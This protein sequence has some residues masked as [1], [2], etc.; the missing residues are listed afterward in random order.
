LPD[1]IANGRTTAFPFIG[2]LKRSIGS[3]MVSRLL[4]GNAGESEVSRAT[5]AERDHALRGDFASAG[6]IVGPSR[7]A[8]RSSR[9]PVFQRIRTIG[10]ELEDGAWYTWKKTDSQPR[11]HRYF[12]TPADSS[13][14]R[15]MAKH[16]V[17]HDG[18]GIRMEAD[19]FDE[20]GMRL[21]DVEFV[22]NP[23]PLST[24]GHAELIRALHQ[25]AQIYSTIIPLRGRDHAEGG[26]V[27]PDEHHLSHTD[28]LLSRG[29]ACARI[30]V[31]ATHGLSLA[32]IPRVYKALSAPPEDQAR[33]DAVA[34]IQLGSPGHADLSS[35]RWLESLR[36]APDRAL[37][38]SLAHIELAIGDDPVLEDTAP[39][40]GFLTA[41]IAFVRGMHAGPITG[42]IKTFL[43]M[44]HRNDFATMFAL[45]PPSQ[46]RLLRLNQTHF[47]KAVLSGVF[48][49]PERGID[50]L[51][52][53][54]HADQP[55]VKSLALN[56][57]ER[58]TFTGGAELPSTLNL[59]DLGARILSY[60][61]L[62]RSLTIERWIQA[63]MSDHNPADLLTTEHFDAAQIDTGGGEPSPTLKAIREAHEFAA[64]AHLINWNQ[65]Y[66]QPGYI[67]NLV[68]D[69]ELLSGVQQA[70][71]RDSVRELGGLGSA[72]DSEHPELALFENRAFR[73]EF[74]NP[75]CGPHLEGSKL[76]VDAAIQA[77][78]S[79]FWGMFEL[80]DGA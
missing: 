56:P 16:E 7:A 54:A 53:A 15:P 40:L 77:I 21:S 43:P 62:P 78:S 18:I 31:Q 24:Q 12:R 75:A 26:F 72:T 34:T 51:D 60:R 37:K 6:K 20:H 55:V 36:S 35:R 2:E 71:L 44:M 50:D 79:Y 65:S 67:V 57:H 58:R 14:V 42:G 23:F 27:G 4:S 30:R 63:W 32:D 29:A 1:E 19:E 41:V 10:F 13:G 66:E 80:F 48:G 64:F 74:E 49:D 76:S 46:R 70:I 25:V 3:S 69:W 22:T 38:L 68:F 59:S 73:P 52:L 28:V 8:A 45:L 33:P 5:T 47:I 9:G 39:L 61:Q 11:R 17:L